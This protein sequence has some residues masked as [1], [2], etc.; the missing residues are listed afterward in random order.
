MRTLYAKYEIT[1]DELNRGKKIHDIVLYR[2]D[3]CVEFAARIPWYYTKS[4]P[5]KSTKTIFLNCAK[6]NLVWVD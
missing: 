5:S 2:D 6:Y 1:T 4:K 3:K